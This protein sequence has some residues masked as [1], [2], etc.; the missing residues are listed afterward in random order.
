MGERIEI[1]AKHNKKRKIIGV[2]LYEK[3]QKKMIQ[4]FGKILNAREARI[5]LLTNKITILEKK[6]NQDSKLMILEL[7]RLGNNINQLAHIANI[8]EEIVL[9]HEIRV[10]L[11]ELKMAINK[12]EEFI[13][14]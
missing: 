14:M 8:S 13:Y 12:A 7:K 1:H 4:K 10:Q 3:D 11:K 9:E 2:S 5:A 6:D